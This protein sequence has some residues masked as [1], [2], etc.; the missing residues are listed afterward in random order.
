MAH[1][2]N[3]G[4]RSAWKY[5]KDLASRRWNGLDNVD[6]EQA[7]KISFTDKVE[8]V[9]RSKILEMVDK[10]QNVEGLSELGK[11]AG[12]FAFASVAIA[13]IAAALAFLDSNTTIASGGQYEY[14][15]WG[16][17]LI[18]AVTS[19]VILVRSKTHL[20][21]LFLVP[22]IFTTVTTLFIHQ[23]F[24]LLNFHL[25]QQKSYH[26]EKVLQTKDHEV[27]RT[28]N[29]EEFKCAPSLRKL[30]DY[31]TGIVRI[32]ILGVVRKQYTEVCM[33]PKEIKWGKSA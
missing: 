26:F 14:L 22:F 31:E 1:T 29:G 32:G 9:N 21:A 25:G 18:I 4:A 28:E 11:V 5:I 3:L 16:V 12:Y 6:L 20:V 2:K 7:L 33:Q 27:W 15:I 23:S 19:L 30:H 24:M 13:G 8:F 10:H 17:A